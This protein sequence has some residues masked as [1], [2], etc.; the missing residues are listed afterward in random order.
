MTVGLITI[1]SISRKLIIGRIKEYVEITFVTTNPIIAGNQITLTFLSNP[2]IFP[3]HFASFK[4]FLK[5][6]WQ[7]NSIHFVLLL[8]SNSFRKWFYI[9]KHCGAMFDLW[10]IS[11]DSRC[12]M[13]HVNHRQYSQCC[14][15]NLLELLDARWIHIYSETLWN[16]Y[17]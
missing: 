6:L 10:D 9:W 4:I 8:I 2:I 17:L 16:G 11:R 5:Y 7:I 1:S 14:H 15:R 12:R 13:L 3:N